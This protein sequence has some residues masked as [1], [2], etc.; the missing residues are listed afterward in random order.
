[1]NQE[2]LQIPA[3]IETI[4]SLEVKVAYQEDTIEALNNVIISQSEKISTLEAKVAAIIEKLGAMA[5]VE[6]A[7]PNLIELP[8]HY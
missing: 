7:D 6:Q 1:M 4:D 3:L 5:P 2:A 8:P